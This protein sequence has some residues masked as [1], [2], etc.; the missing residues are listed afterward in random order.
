MKLFTDK[1]NSNSIRIPAEWEPHNSC[2]MAW[3]VHPE[4]LDWVNE[5]KSELAEII[6][7]IAKFETV[8]L[9]TPPQELAEAKARFSGGNVEIIEAPV[10]DIWMRDI[11]PTF[12]FRGNK[13]VAIDWN[14]N[15]WGSTKE[16]PVRPGDHLARIAEKVF[17]VPH[18][19]VPIVADGGAMITDGCG[20]LITTRSCL[21][22]PNR[23]SKAIIEEEIEREFAKLGIHQTIWLEGNRDEPITSGHIDGYVLFK[24]QSS[25]LV[26]VIDDPHVEPPVWQSRDIEAL[27]QAADAAKRILNVERV[28]APRRRF[29][30]FRGEMFAPCYLNAYIANGAVITAG[31]GDIE[32][33]EAAR[34]ALERSFPGRAIV[35]LS[36]DHI[37][38]GGGGVHCLTQPMLETRGSRAEYEN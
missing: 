27:E 20:T 11:A 36:I 8:Q 38:A 35:M 18:V 24:A 22:N 33:D 31:F 23:N 29:W 5:V 16:R 13:I 30:K 15:G 2:W 1:T 9:L 37:A 14:F 21:L 6:C 26:E 12:A 17:G 4:W 28:K 32:R 3:A 34:F 7:T 25:V 19:S 10:D